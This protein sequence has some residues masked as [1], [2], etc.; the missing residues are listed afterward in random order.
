LFLLVLQ[1]AP[2]VFEAAVLPVKRAL[3]DLEVVPELLLPLAEDV[4]L[5]VVLALQ[6][7]TPVLLLRVGLFAPVVVGQDALLGHDLV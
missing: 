3:E 6:E 5:G 1:I 4:H 2:A 7:A